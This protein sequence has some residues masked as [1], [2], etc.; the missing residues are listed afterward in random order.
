MRGYWPL[1]VI[2]AGNNKCMQCV[3]IAFQFNMAVGWVLMTRWA[4]T[5][6][7]TFSTSFISSM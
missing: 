5:L 1:R 4:V 2:M 7:L 6:L 3:S